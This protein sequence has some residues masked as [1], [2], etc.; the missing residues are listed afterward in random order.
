MACASPLASLV[1]GEAAETNECVVV[2]D[3]LVKTVY[4]VKDT[5]RITGSS[6][7]FVA[8]KSLD[9]VCA[10][11]NEHILRLEHEFAISRHL[12]SQCASVASALS[13]SQFDGCPAIFLEWAVGA[14]LS[15]WI[16]LLHKEA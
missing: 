12:A 15:E 2:A 16:K 1:S 5:E 9:D 7:G 13:L 10:H 6:T 14:T 8:V 3:D 4:C 11:D